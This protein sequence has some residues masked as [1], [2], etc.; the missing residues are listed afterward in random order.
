MTTTPQLY[1]F[2]PPL[3]TLPFLVFSQVQQAEVH[4]VGPEQAA[5]ARG[6]QTQTYE[7]SEEAQEVIHQH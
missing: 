3:D 4:R 1:P 7:A 6:A 5:N 2:P